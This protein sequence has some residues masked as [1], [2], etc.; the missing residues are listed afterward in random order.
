MRSAILA[1]RYYSG[2]NPACGHRAVRWV[3]AA[4]P[5]V[6]RDPAAVFLRAQRLLGARVVPA[7]EPPPQSAGALFAR[8]AL[9]L[10]GAHYH[11]VSRSMVRRLDS[12]WWEVVV[13]VLRESIAPPLAECLCALVDEAAGSAMPGSFDAVRENHR[14]RLRFVLLDFFSNHRRSAAARL[15]VPVWYD[16]PQQ[17]YLGDGRHASLTSPTVT[18]RTSRVGGDLC[19]DK[20]LT[21]RRLAACAVPVPRQATAGTVEAAVEAALHIGWPVVVKPQ[22]GMKGKGVTVNLRSVA[23][24]RRA[25]AA[26]RP[27][28]SEIV[29]E[30]FIRGADHRLLVIGGRFVAAVRRVPPYLVGDGS[31]TVRQLIA[32]AN[33]QDRRDGMWLYVLNLDAEMRATLATLGLAPDSVPDKGRRFRLR[34]VA[35]H[36]L[37]GTTVDVT[38]RVHPDNRA[39]AEAAA[40]ACL[41]DVAG[42]DFMTPDIGRSWREGVGAVIEVNKGPGFSLH[43][44]P[45]QGKPRDVSRHLVRSVHPAR[46][47]G[48]V[49]RF[50]VAGEGGEGVARSLSA[51]LEQSGH[52]TGRL[53]GNEAAVD[54]RVF[55]EPGA[56]RAAERLFSL[57]DVDAV[58][59]E[60]SLK[61]L[62][63]EGSMVERYAVGVITDAGGDTS[64]LEE[65]LL[66]GSAAERV[67]DLVVWLS[68]VVVIDA[69]QAR[70][71]A[72]TSR[73]A[74]T[75][76]GWVWSEA[77]APAGLAAH[78][79]AG[80]FAVGFEADAAGPALVLR[81]G[82]QR[83]VLGRYELGGARVRE[84]A[85]AAAALVGAGM[86]AE[87]VAALLRGERGARVPTL[88]E[89]ARGEVPAALWSRD[90]LEQAFDGAWIQRPGPGWRA[91]PLVC[92][93]ERVE[94][95]AVA[96]IDGPADELEAVAGLEAAVREAFERGASAVV[97]PLLPDDLPRWHPVLVCDAPQAGFESARKTVT[98]SC[99]SE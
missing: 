50:L 58:V 49:P 76:V 36:S 77:G 1:S 97:A 68:S 30:R 72:H 78:L 81:V 86:A 52:C 27:F 19:S 88:A 93:L 22:Q 35:S 28:G 37:G 82:T 10:Q 3:V 7:G 6:T 95:G 89:R 41:L 29:V 43:V 14:N 57:P 2:P 48:L 85:F 62:A 66:D 18:G 34:R 39:M 98:S 53:C 87:A 31:K 13:E 9:A 56:Q 25:Y 11:P 44:M 83:T 73:L 51:R 40:R 59:V 47:P 17:H 45:N 42:I 80:G 67:L 54:G 20:R 15:G 65:V 26:A 75:Q 69:A 12:G 60:Q 33:R 8:L 16:G 74:A 21:V 94:A 5:T 96:V 71:R 84:D 91:G 63:G 61:A 38:D 32:D 4:S 90:A 92:G 46:S 23:A 70:L 24:V 79:E 99:R 55:T 64:V